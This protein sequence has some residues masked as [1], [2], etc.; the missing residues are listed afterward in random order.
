MV[1]KKAVVVYG[2]P[3][4]KKSG[5]FHLGDNF[6][7]GLKKGGVSVEEIMVHKKN[8]K[9]CRGCFTCWTKTPGKC[10]HHDDMEEILP[11]IDE[12]D[13][14]VFAVPL[15]IYSVPGPVKTFLDRQLPLAEPYLVEKDGIT[16]HPRRTKGKTLKAFILSVAGF[17]ELS[18]FDAMIATFKKLFKPN[19][20][21]Y[22]GEILIGGANQ[23][24]DDSSQNAYVDLYK[25]IQ[26]AGFE[27]SKDERVSTS[28]LK[29]IQDLTSFTPEQ[30]KN[31]QKVANL[32]WDTFIEKDYTQGEIAQ[33]D[34]QPLKI[35]DGKSSA[36]FATMATQY[37]PNAFPGMKSII[38]FE[39]ETD[40]Y[41]LI[42]DEAN[43]NAFAG[44]YPKPTLKIK[45]PEDIWMKIAAGE[46]S[47]QKSF[48]DG[49]YTIEGDMNL[50]LNLNKMFAR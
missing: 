29:Q 10:V 45:S 17:P 15:Y 23:M 24:S 16:T 40:S 4:L 14:I 48:M 2:S 19:D 37:N 12:A 25:L 30:V 5:S 32:Y 3:R 41:Y 46:L 34:D 47:G 31:L 11:I 20:E 13:L 22:L 28:T 26:Q 33:T 38:Q 7:I 44:T 27:I 21:R 8:I 6:A 49:L 1:I 35:S 43:C 50:L 18:H 42:I 36:Y 9:P 39:F